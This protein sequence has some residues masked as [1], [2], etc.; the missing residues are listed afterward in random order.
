MNTKPKKIIVIVSAV[1]AIAAGLTILLINGFSG[2]GASDM[3][4]EERRVL[5]FLEDSEEIE[6]IKY[7]NFLESSD[8]GYRDYNYYDVVTE[9]GK[10]YIAE[11][12]DNNGDMEYIGKSSYTNSFNRST[13][14]KDMIEYRSSEQ[15]QHIDSIND[16]LADLK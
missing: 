10:K 2:A 15:G 16:A 4:G 7:V 13:I 14:L 8:N 12:A 3:S 9:D 11:I 5:S 1:I 6:D